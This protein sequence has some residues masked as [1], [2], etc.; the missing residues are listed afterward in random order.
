MTLTEYLETNDMD[1]KAE[2]NRELI[3]RYPWVAPKNRWNGEIP[4]NYK[5]TYTELDNIPRGW[6]LA[7][8]DS[9]LEEL[10]KELVKFDY[11]DKYEITQ[12]KENFGGLRWYDNGTPL[13]K[14]ST[15]YKKVIVRGYDTLPKFDS[16]KFVLK[17][18]YSDHYIS[19][20]DARD[21]GM[22]LDEINAYNRDAVHY[23][24]LYRLLDRC[25]VSGIVHK[26]ELMSYNICR[27][28]GKPAKYKIYEAPVCGE[29]AEDITKNRSGLAV[30]PI[31]H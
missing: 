2:F 18:D 5:Y 21:R 14:L 27:F 26:Y 24:R 11:V 16:G 6:R 7:F 23:Y 13:G 12:I 3:S 19:S 31:L 8:I 30:E 15:N 28:C 10:H 25:N 17:R 4:E 1:K 9:M 22:S 20:Y 29:C